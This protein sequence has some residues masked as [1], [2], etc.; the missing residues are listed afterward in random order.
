MSDQILEIVV[1]YSYSQL[2]VNRTLTNKSV[3][4]SW[5]IHKSIKLLIME[6]QYYSFNGVVGKIFTSM[7]D[8]N[9]WRQKWQAIRDLATVLELF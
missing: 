9:V 2:T 6:I 5:I 3:Y 4:D 7:H 8:E 1:A